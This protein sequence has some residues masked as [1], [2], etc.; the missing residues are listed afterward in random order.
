MSFYHGGNTYK[1]HLWN[2]DTSARSQDHTFYPLKTEHL[3]SKDIFL[4]PNGLRV[5]HME[6][7]IH[8]LPCS[9]EEE[10]LGI[11]VGDLTQEIR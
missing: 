1:G 4:G 9:K 2:E 3:S 5:P 7:Y 10:S 6:I 8:Y 11:L